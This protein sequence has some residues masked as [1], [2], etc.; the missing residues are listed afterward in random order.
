[1]DPGP[2]IGCDE[3]EEDAI[4]AYTHALAWIFSEDQRH[5]DKAV[6]IL[7]A[8]AREHKACTNAN[9]ALVSGWATAGFVNA[10]ELL[11]HYPQ[12]PSGWSTTNISVFSDYLVEVHLPLSQ[13][14]SI[15]PNWV[16]TL[17]E[18][19]MSISVFVED[20]G[21]FERSVHKWRIDIVRSV[22]ESND[23][24]RPVRVGKKTDLEMNKY[25]Y[26]AWDLGKFVDGMSMETCRDLSHLQ[27]G[28]YGI[29]GTAEIAHNQGVDLYKMSG[30]HTT[31]SKRIR[32]LMEF[33]AG[34]LV[35]EYPEEYP[36]WLCNGT[37]W[38]DPRTP[39][40]H[41]SLRCTDTFAIGYNQLV[42][43]MGVR[44][45]NTAKLLHAC[46]NT[47][48]HRPNYK[49]ETLTN[50]IVPTSCSPYCKVTGCGWT[51]ANACGSGRR[52]GR[53]GIISG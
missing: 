51:P 46:G 44:M 13:L 42:N 18:S 7:M 11:R 37:I 3:I 45:P 36:S 8:W 26:G 19:A 24:N 35:G 48:A 38:L 23:G 28:V 34:L 50:N 14:W 27:L 40:K 49:W 41:A 17:L 39:I 53:Y 29:T 32:D 31:Y 15:A 52:P 9:R 22:Y 2:N 20:K 21:L 1:M 16:F 4:A 10:A 47:A 5:A 25:W 33:H 43:R 12:R 30:H 6:A